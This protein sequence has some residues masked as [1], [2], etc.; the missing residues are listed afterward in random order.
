MALGKILREA[1]EQQGYSIAQVAEATHMMTQIVEE[2]EREDFHRIAA[3][4]YGRGFIKL[5]CDFLSIDP[6]PLVQEF[7]AIYSGAHRPAVATRTLKKTVASPA[8][9]PRPLEGSAPS[10]QPAAPAHQ[11]PLASHAS[12]LA[13]SPSPLEGSAPPP[14]PAS[15]PAT[16]AT[17]SSLSWERSS[18][19]APPRASTPPLEDAALSPPQPAPAA[20]QPAPPARQPLPASH[21]SPV[22]SSP[23]PAR[24]E[25]RLEAEPLERQQT[26]AAALDELFGHKGAARS[27]TGAASSERASPGGPSRATLLGRRCRELFVDLFTALR[28][29]LDNTAS[30]FS[31][32]AAIKFEYRKLYGTLTVAVV[33]F[34]ALLLLIINLTKPRPAVALPEGYT[35]SEVLPPPEAYVD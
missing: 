30:L 14:Q 23:A 5:Y 26:T 8:A 12:P 28:R 3:P 24:P 2:L 13:S 25:L 4:I 35:I 11:P 10:P 31:R 21:I 20:P 15:T 34:I 7:N 33:L 1:R 6:E 19:S 29:G 9:S 16:P 17:P 22:T 18:V 27:G 32:A